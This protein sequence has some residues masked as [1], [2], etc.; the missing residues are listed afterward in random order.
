MIYRVYSS[1]SNKN[2]L[3]TFPYFPHSVFLRKKGVLRGEIR[4]TMKKWAG[5]L[6]LGR[7]HRYI[8]SSL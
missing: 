4:K 2:S 5:V 1:Y 3:F 7:K 6:E 8:L